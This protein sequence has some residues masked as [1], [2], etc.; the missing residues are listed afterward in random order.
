M[1]YIKFPFHVKHD[2]RDYRP[3]EA[4]EVDNPEMY[5]LRGAVIADPPA[6]ELPRPKRR[7]TSKSS[8]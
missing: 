3:G 1:A 6:A 2:G 4:I 8:E 5:L 7:K